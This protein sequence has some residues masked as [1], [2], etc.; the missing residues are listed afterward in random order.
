MIT[1]AREELDSEV[2]RQL[3][4]AHSEP[5]ALRGDGAMS[6]VERAIMS[7]LVEPHSR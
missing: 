6:A 2:A 5:F 1:I 3:I 4:A 7:G